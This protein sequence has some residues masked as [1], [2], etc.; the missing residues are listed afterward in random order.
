MNSALWTT[1]Q[2]MQWRQ[3]SASRSD[4]ALWAGEERAGTLQIRGWTQSDVTGTT[5][6]NT[7]VIKSEGFLRQMFHVLDADRKTEIATFSPNGWT[8]EGTISLANGSQ[9]SWKVKNMWKGIY[10]VTDLKQNVLLETT[11]GLG[12][13][14]SGFK[15]WFK[16]QSRVRVSPDGHA[17]ATISLLALISWCFV[18]NYR[19]VQSG[20]VVATG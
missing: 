10:I 19:E 12:A 8:G 9:F 3:E 16:T 14:R 6:Y 13:G 18:L 7:I 11:M 15:D 17:P 20:A 4:Y 1:S 2:E 5:A